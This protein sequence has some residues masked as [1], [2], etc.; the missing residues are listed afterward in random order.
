ML[1]LY[2]VCYILMCSL[3]N[4]QIYIFMR[5]FLL[6]RKRVSFADP[7]VSKEMGYEISTSE[8]PQKTIKYSMTRTPTPRKDSPMKSKQ[9]KLKLV[10]FD[11]EKMITEDNNIQVEND[12]EVVEVEKE[13]ELLTKISEVCTDTMDINEQIPDDSIESSNII[14]T[15]SC[16]R[17]DIIDE[18]G[19]AQ[20][21]EITTDSLVPEDQQSLSSEDSDDASPIDVGTEDSETQQ[22]IF[23]GMDA[24][25]NV[26]VIQRGND[27]NIQTVIR[28][29]LIDSVK[30]NV[31]DDSVI[32]ALPTKDDNL[33]NMEDTIDIQN[34]TGLNSTVNTD[35]IFCEKPIRSSTHAIENVAEQ[36]TLSVTD[37]IFASLSST[38]SIQNQEA[39]NNAELDPEFL[40]STQPIYPTLSLCMEPIDNIIEQ[41]TYPLWK[42]SLS[43]YFANRNMRTIGDFAQLSEREVNRMPVKGKS[44]TE[45]VKKV[46]EHF[47]ST[48]I[49]QTESSNKKS[50]EVEQLPTKATD[51]EPTVPIAVVSNVETESA[52][53]DNESLICNTPLIQVAE[54]TSD[55]LSR[56][57]SPIENLDKTESVTSDMDISLE[58]M[59]P[60]NTDLSILDT[61][62]KDEQKNAKISNSAQI[63]KPETSTNNNNA[64]PI[65]SSSESRYVIFYIFI[66]E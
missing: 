16:A 24:K 63:L 48:C 61:S 33:I 30:L 29:N 20:E 50:N 44:K 43:M 51:E 58:P 1:Y 47:E 10:P 3:L 2:F 57:N 34:I 52:T 22:D 35:E 12:T 7:P 25:T 9:T 13:N 14:K 6:Q 36:D 32:A 60:D 66:L 8:S 49:L 15:N 53:I 41:L 59:I 64:E 37:S 56:E 65:P 39:S 45:F 19:L 5:C 27:D 18:L 28:N 17:I 11:T 31:T 23:D 26:T 55:N 38:P 21:I 42:H 62:K 54:N 4:S 46:L 40:D